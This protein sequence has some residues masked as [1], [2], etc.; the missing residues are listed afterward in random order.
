MEGNLYEIGYHLV[1]TL[2]S[3]TLPKEVGALRK[4]VEKAGTVVSEGQPEERALAY[5]ITRM[6]SGKNAHHDRA[7]FGWFTIEVTDTEKVP[8]LQEELKGMQSVLRFIVVGT[9]PHQA[10]VPKRRPKSILSKEKEE[11]SATPEVKPA[12][13]VAPASAE[14][15]DKEIEKLIVE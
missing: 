9:E 3:E 5:T 13:P 15:L 2:T 1:S 4:A 10:P 6:E 7:H 14:D 11:E 8:A 12:A